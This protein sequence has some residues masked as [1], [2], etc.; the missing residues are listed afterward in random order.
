M[1]RTTE[2]EFVQLHCRSSHKKDRGG[3]YHPGEQ[4][5]GER[6]LAFQLGVN[7]NSLREALRVLEF[8][9]VVEKRAGE[10]VFVLDPA[11]D[12]SLEAVVQHMLLE[13]GLD[14]DSVE[15]TY[16]A[17]VIV[18]VHLARLAARKGNEAEGW[19]GI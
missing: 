10:G 5:P 13:D 2:S 16:E 6:D 11:R 4:L 8:M 18:E 7:R 14:D 15:S 19:R 17:I 3:H 12:V 9:C 1:L